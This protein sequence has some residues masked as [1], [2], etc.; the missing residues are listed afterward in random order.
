MPVV[1]GKA[2]PPMVLL[3]DVQVVEVESPVAKIGIYFRIAFAGDRL[4][5]T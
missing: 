1:A 3:V 4:I 2:G 5:V